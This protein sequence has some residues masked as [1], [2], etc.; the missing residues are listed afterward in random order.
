[1]KKR[2]MTLALAFAL[3]MTG[4]PVSAADSSTPAN[5]TTET[6]ESTSVVDANKIPRQLNVHVGTDAS[7]QVNVTY[8]T[9]ADTETMITLNKVGSTEEIRFTGTSYKGIG[10]K[11]I[12]EIAVTGL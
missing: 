4:I 10:G 5:K 11:Y 8:T 1:M 2:M 9:V 6:V 7:S 12:H 3:T